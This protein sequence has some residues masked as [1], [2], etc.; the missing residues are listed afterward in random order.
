MPESLHPSLLNCS[1]GRDNDS[2][3]HRPKKSLS[4]FLREK[5]EE[6]E[7]P[8]KIHLELKPKSSFVWSRK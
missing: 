8:I 5:I 2:F 6:T 1:F 7:K 4:I 3:E